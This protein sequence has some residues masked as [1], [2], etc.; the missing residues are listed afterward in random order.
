LRIFI[1]LFFITTTSISIAQINYSAPWVKEMEIPFN[2]KILFNDVVDSGNAYWETR[3]KNAKGSGYKP[4]KRWEA[5]WQNYVD[6]SGYLPSR[7]QIWDNWLKKTNYSQMRTSI[8]S[9]TDESNWIS[10]GPTDFINRSRS[11]LNLGRV[12]CITPHP[13]NPDIVYVG[14]PSGGI[15]KSIDGGLTYVALSDT[16]PQIGVSS[17]AI[18]HSNPDIVYIA[19]G[20]DDAGDSY[21][22]GIWKSNNGGYS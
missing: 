15:W 18:D 19:T 7:Q 3:D 4:F 6:D 9:T 10:V 21:S 14:T 11:Y 5:Y 1:K 2:E 16:L 17:I 12:N 22:V 13:T 8:Q 20:D